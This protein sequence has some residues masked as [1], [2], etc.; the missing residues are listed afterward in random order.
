MNLLPIIYYSLLIVGGMLAIVLLISFVA[1]KLRRAEKESKQS[2]YFVQRYSNYESHNL[3]PKRSNEQY[4]LSNYKRFTQNANPRNSYNPVHNYS[5]F[6]EIQNRLTQFELANNSV[7]NGI[8]TYSL[9]SNV[10]RERY[11]RVY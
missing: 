8:I 11:K 1:H 9:V 5:P 2:N 4:T 10:S 6:D 3:Q 7:N